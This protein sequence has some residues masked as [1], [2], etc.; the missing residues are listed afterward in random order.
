M[1]VKK[2]KAEYM[3]LT[4]LTNFLFICLMS[5]YP[6]KGFLNLFLPDIDS[7]RTYMFLSVSFLFLVL[8]LYGIK[9]AVA[10]KKLFIILLIWFFYLFIFYYHTQMEPVIPF[11]IAKEYLTPA[12][13]ILYQTFFYIGLAFYVFAKK[14]WMEDVFYKL[15][16]WGTCLS[17]SLLLYVFYSQGLVFFYSSSL[18]IENTSITL[19]NMSYN[20]VFYAVL[21]LY[22][23]FYNNDRHS[24][25]IKWG[26]FLVCIISILIMGKRG[27]LLSVLGAAVCLYVFANK[28]WQKSLAYIGSITLLYYVVVMNID[29]LFDLLSVFS[30]RLA[31]QTRLAYYFGDVNGRDLLWETAIDQIK[32][33]LFWG[34]YPKLILMDYLSFG[35]GMH[36]HNIFLESMMTMGLVGSIPFFILIVFTIIRKVY[37]FIIIGGPYRFFG[38]LFVSEIIH[39]CFSGILYNSWIWPMMFV[40][41]IVS[42]KDWWMKSRPK[43]HI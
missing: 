9:Q 43:L 10:L 15:M 34:Y 8:T 26:C 29:Y 32:E 11:K 36:P 27:A 24:K 1:Y 25:V 12:K 16:L 22:M 37:P 18:K 42:S 30:Q 19:I 28:T 3:K 13:I 38:L 40:F 14:L 21:S 5:W 7:S 33:G 6:I 17:F 35:W 31:D 23:I 20:F 2:E 41:S 39:N 4:T